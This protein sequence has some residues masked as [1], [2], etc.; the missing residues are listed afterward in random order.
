MKQAGNGTKLGRRPK[1]DRG[2][3]VRNNGFTENQ[4]K[5]LQEEAS[6]KRMD[7]MELARHA[8]QWYIDSVEASR[9]GSIATPQ[10]DKSFETIIKSNH[11]RKVKRSN[12]S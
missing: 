12:K 11:K 4:W 9:N 6:K 2:E 8:V 3:I 5:W 7:A 1:E 10:D